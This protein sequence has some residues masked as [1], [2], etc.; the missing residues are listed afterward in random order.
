MAQT[1]NQAALCA[2]AGSETHKFTCVLRGNAFFPAKVGFYNYEEKLAAFHPNVHNFITLR[3]LS[4]QSFY[5]TVIHI[6]TSNQTGLFS[7]R[8]Y[9][10]VLIVGSS[11]VRRHN[12]SLFGFLLFEAP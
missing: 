10:A 3:H 9:T 11:F 2:H 4:C 12:I 7:A 6:F 5:S 1:I 8:S